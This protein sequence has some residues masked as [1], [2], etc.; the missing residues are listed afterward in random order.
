[1]PV[2]QIDLESRFAGWQVKAIM[3]WPN[4]QLARNNFLVTVAAGAMQH[5]QDEL[6]RRVDRMLPDI[7]SRVA[8]TSG[9][10]IGI[11]RA[12]VAAQASPALVEAAVWTITVEIDWELFRPSGGYG[13]VA[14][15]EGMEAI[16]KATKG[17]GTFG[18]ACGMLLTYIV[19][20]ATHHPDIPASLNR[21]I[22]IWVNC[23]KKDGRRI[24][25]ERDRKTMWT[26]WGGVSPLWAAG[27]FCYAA[28]KAPGS[29]HLT[30]HDPDFRRE[31]ISVSL[32][33]ADFAVRFKAIGAR[34]PLLSEDEVVRVDC[35][36]DAVRP[37]IPPLTDEEL[38][39]ARSYRAPI[40]PP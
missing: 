5:V 16:Q 29:P 38:T 10:P 26:R 24:P 8:A 39:W 14:A 2:V 3:H 35:N 12:L 4:D 19:R 22:Y 30:Y 7:A 25:A 6:P 32:W 15:A 31:M 28:A 1:V 36:L 18:A 21:A 37:E 27:A 40:P 11:A 33:L 17:Q 13:R 9:L 34:T 20:L 23:A